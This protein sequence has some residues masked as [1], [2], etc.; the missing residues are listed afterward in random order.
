M[1]E[2]TTTGA[3]SECLRA[4]C[5]DALPACTD[6]PGCNCMFTCITAGTPARDCV[7]MCTPDAHTKEFSQ[8]AMKYCADTCE[9]AAP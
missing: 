3:C 5:C 8:C 6:P 4:A 2:L 7:D 9:G 1:A